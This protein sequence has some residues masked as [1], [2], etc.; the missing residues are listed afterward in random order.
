[1]FPIVNK[2]QSVIT[3]ETKNFQAST[4]LYLLALKQ[5]IMERT[6]FI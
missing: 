1:M 4:N 5:N 6:Q 3:W 2:V